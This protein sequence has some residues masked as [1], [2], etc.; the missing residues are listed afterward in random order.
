LSAR[1]EVIASIRSA[2]RDVPENEAPPTIELP[3]APPVEA[4]GVVALFV[5]R[6]EEYRGAVRRADAS[7]IAGAVSEVLGAGRLLMAPGVDDSWIPAG[8]EGV[9]DADFPASELDGFDGVLTGCHLAIAETGTIVLD[10]GPMSGRRAISLVPDLH[11]CVVRP[12]QIVRSVPEA[13]DRLRDRSRAPLTF[14]SGPSAT[15]DIEFNRVEGVHGPRRL[16]V[17]LTLH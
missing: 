6:V 15:S 16:E 7:E 9:R 11:I 14:I 5:E 2:L 4:E 10:G 1:E 17:I 3:I 8:V 12:D 13:F